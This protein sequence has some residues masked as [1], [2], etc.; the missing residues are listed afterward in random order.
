[1]ENSSED[2][3]QLY[4]I[5]GKAGINWRMN[6]KLLTRAYNCHRLKL[7]LE[8]NK[9][10]ENGPNSK[11]NANQKWKGDHDAKQPIE[12]ENKTHQGS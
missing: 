9:K 10:A 4:K 12:E 7:W 5:S 6:G 11:L 1:M 3:T 8:P 2:R